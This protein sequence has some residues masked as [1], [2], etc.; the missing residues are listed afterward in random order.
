M[1]AGSSAR[2]IVL[3]PRF[4]IH[5]TGRT[6]SHRSSP[7]LYASS[8]SRVL[9]ILYRIYRDLTWRARSPRP[10]EAEPSPAFLPSIF[11]L[12]APLPPVN[13]RQSGSTGRVVNLASERR[14][15]SQ[16]PPGLPRLSKYTAAPCARRVAST[17]SLRPA[18]S[19]HTAVA[20]RLVSPV[21]LGFT[22]W[23]CICC[24]PDALVSRAAFTA[25]RPRAN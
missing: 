1:F 14:A 2:A 3:T 19:S 10:G 6:H 11:T 9:H 16:P 24:P 13:I 18:R 5:T 12:V 4:F 21:K 15:F 17:L 25:T 7:R 20:R 8:R 23:R 22:A